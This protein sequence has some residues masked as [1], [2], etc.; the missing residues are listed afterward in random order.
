MTTVR[1][2]AMVEKCEES[3]HRLRSMKS[4]TQKKVKYSIEMHIGTLSVLFVSNLICEKYIENAD[5][6]HYIINLAN[7]QTLAF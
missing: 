3:A 7:S 5:E 2:N 4:I 6:T 1:V